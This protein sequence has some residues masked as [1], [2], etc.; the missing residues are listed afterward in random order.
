MTSD[1]LERQH[2]SIRTACVLGGS[3]AGL[4]SARVL[5][6]HA[7]RVLVIERDPLGDAPSVRPSVPQSRHGHFLQPDGLTQIEEWF[8]GFTDDARAHGAILAPPGHQRLFTDG[9]AVSFPDMTIL[10]ATRPL[11]ESEI[12]RRVMAL[13]NVRIVRGQ[14]VGLLHDA[15][16]V[17]G[18]S[19]QEYDAAGA[20]TERTVDADITVDAMGRGSRLRRW[21]SESGLN[22]PDVRREPVNLSYAT[23][24]FS[25]PSD[26]REPEIGT[27]LQQ[28]TTPP[29][30][31][32]HASEG[33]GLA[34]I[35]YYAVE[36]NRWQVV[37]MTY[38]SAQVPM[39]ACNLRDLCATLPD[40]FRQ[41]TAGDAI[42]EA[43]TFY[44]R[45]ARRR[46]ITDPRQLP[47]GL[48]SIG[49]SVASF[50]PIHGQGITSAASQAAALG[51]HLTASSDPAGQLADF[52]ERQEKDVDQ[53]WNAEE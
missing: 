53:I 25:R 1:R 45:D 22:A 50:N 28:F 31:D 2:A 11:L 17:R 48:V 24:L 32:Q 30:D 43:A 51:A 8:P 46:Q 26:P 35:A 49:D 7:E 23:A 13:P 44:Y 20:T 29:P 34:G 5:A 40:I 15:T 52:T 19:Y 10:C 16:T 36:G 6:D 27:A 3:I 18:A 21:L 14:A 4:F 41:A 12:R 47:A 9:T 39:T 33:R 42:G 38:S 37:A